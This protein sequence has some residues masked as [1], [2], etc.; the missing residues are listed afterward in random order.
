MLKDTLPHY[1]SKKM[2]KQKQ[3]QKPVSNKLQKFKKHDKP[4]AGKYMD[5]WKPFT[6]I[7]EIWTQ[8][9]ILGENWQY[10]INLK[11]RKTPDQVPPRLRM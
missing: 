6:Q 7:E 4:S 10:L 2:Q 5:W 9:F 1:I 3:K 11:I 8:T